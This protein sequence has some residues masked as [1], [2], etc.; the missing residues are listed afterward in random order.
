MIQHRGRLLLLVST[1]AACL[2]SIAPIIETRFDP[3][4]VLMAEAISSCD[5]PCSR[6]ATREMRR[7][8]RS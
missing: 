1:V 6:C 5:L 4:A 3:S 8:V 2:P 7:V